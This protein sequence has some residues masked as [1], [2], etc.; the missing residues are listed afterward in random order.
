MRILV[1][2]DKFKRAASAIEIARAI[3]DGARAARSDLQLDLCPLAD[4]GEGIGEI[5][6]AVWNADPATENPCAI[7]YAAVHDPLGRPIRAPWRRHGDTALIEMPDAAGYKLLRDVERDPMRAS[8]FGLGELIRAALDAGCARVLLGVGGSATVDGGA[9]ALSALGCVF[10]DQDGAA[11][12]RLVDA[13]EIDRIAAMDSP[14]RLRGEIELLC[15][16]SNPLLG[17]NGAAP[18][19][20]PQKGAT[21]QQIPPLE[22]RLERLA[23]VYQRATGVDV[24]DAPHAGAAGGLPAGIMAAFGAK[25]RRGF[26]F[27]ASAVGL[28]QRI[29]NA[30][31]IITG[32]G[33]FDDQTAAGKVV[34]GVLERCAAAQKPVWVVTGADARVASQPLEND[35]AS[36]RQRVLVVTPPG[37][38]VD[39][40]LRQ[41]TAN[42]SRAVQD[43]LQKYATE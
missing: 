24:R 19:F 34:A 11:L 7:E 16:V 25:A 26:D 37:T 33:Q 12:P 17:P 18:V 40:A 9:G 2:P 30:N 27:V 20:A 4:G 28:E 36:A 8:T 5:V 23:E 41:T 15:D 10:R 38:P 29:A 32:E 39:T 3:A 6:S 35:G 42:I 14:P 21:P 43:A 31:L 22:R 13:N 1:A